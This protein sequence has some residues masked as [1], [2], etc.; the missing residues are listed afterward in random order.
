[1]DL[2]GVFLNDLGELLEVERTLLQDVLPDLVV[3]S[4]NSHLR[5]A[6]EKHITE[7][8]RHVQNVEQVFEQLGEKPRTVRSHGLEGLRRQHEESL[9]GVAGLTLRDV[10]HAGAAA[11]TEHY[12][13]SA[14]HSLIHAAELLGEPEAVHLLEQNLHDEEEALEKLEKSIPE[15]L[16][17]ELIRA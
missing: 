5:E 10:I 16:S 9:G 8:R 7:T 11:H 13:I 1:M 2:R 3:Q 17:E 14:Y 4:R 15:K 12:E 6:F